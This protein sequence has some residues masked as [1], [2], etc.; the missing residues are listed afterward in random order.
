[1][2]LKNKS[3]RLS[4]IIFLLC[5]AGMAQNQNNASNLN[6][7]AQA[8]ARAKADFNRVAALAR[9]SGYVNLGEEP[10]I[11]T[12]GNLIGFRSQNLM[13][14]RRLDSRT[15]PGLDIREQS[16]FECFSRNR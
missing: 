13:F 2:T 12:Q 10:N 11:E 15:Y 16:A 6:V 9:E 5:R 7:P 4:T 3:F 14:S 8:A 1:M